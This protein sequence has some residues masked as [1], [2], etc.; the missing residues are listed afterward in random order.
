MHGTPHNTT[1]IN[2]LRNK[3]ATVAL[4]LCYISVA[5]L[6]N[7]YIFSQA[8]HE[9]DRD[10]TNGGCS[11]CIR[12]GE[13][14]DLIRQFRMIFVGVATSVLV[15]LLFVMWVLRFGSNAIE[16]VTLVNLKT[17]MNN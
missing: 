9:H 1:K 14:Q 2:K 3:V 4:L 10:G 6:S 15:N 11:I 7:A 8:N 17:R 5:L 12:M 16:A 13:S